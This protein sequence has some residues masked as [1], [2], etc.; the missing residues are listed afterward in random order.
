MARR[1]GDA[2]VPDVTRIRVA[3]VRCVG[4]LLSTNAQRM[5]CAL[6]CATRCDRRC[7]STD[8]PGVEGTLAPPVAAKLPRQHRC[9]RMLHRR[10]RRQHRHQQQ[11]QRALH[12]A[13]R[14]VVAVRV[15]GRQRRDAEPCEYR[16]VDTS[17]CLFSLVEVRN[18]QPS[19]L[20]SGS[21]RAPVDDEVL[22]PEHLDAHVRHCLWL[23][24]T[25]ATSTAAT[26]NIRTARARTLSP[27]AKSMG[28]STGSMTISVSRSLN[29][30][31][32]SSFRWYS[33]SA[34]HS[35]RASITIM[36]LRG[37]TQRAHRCTVAHSSPHSVARTL[38][39]WTTAAP[40]RRL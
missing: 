38:V 31:H 24:R 33:D 8:L 25:A 5:A 2:S 6:L 21:Y 4:Y 15:R 16:N 10:R 14:P 40:A 37:H 36:H 29:L 30:A 17:C 35:P 39:G 32:A 34:R 22:R 7:K 18:G 19:T 11:R 12:V 28:F 13:T 26:C 1:C 9:W 27:W 3:L 20:G 23:T